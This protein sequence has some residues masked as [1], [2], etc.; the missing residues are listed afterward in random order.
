MRSLVV[1]LALS[2][3]LFAM[4]INDPTWAVPATVHPGQTFVLKAQSPVLG[5]KANKGD[6]S[7]NL[8]I[9]GKGNEVKAFVPP[10][11]QPGLYDLI[12]KTKD[13]TCYQHNALWILGSKM[14]RLTLMHLTDEHFGVYDPS[15]R[16]AFQYVL[17]AVI[18]ANSDPNVTAVVA[19]GDIADTAMPSQYEEARLIHG[20][21]TKPVFII[22]GNH[23]HVSAE[24]TYS[25]YVGPHTW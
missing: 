24:D 1:L 12:V 7:F 25:Q 5:A 23:D 13:G 22:P 15:G 11:A 2:L 14:H 20:L 17:A 18:I 10:G 19:T 6:F 8:V 9:I 4:C 21:L 16:R 3:A